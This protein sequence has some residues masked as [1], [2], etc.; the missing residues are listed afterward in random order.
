MSSVRWGGGRSKEAQRGRLGE[1]T[2]DARSLPCAFGAKEP[3]DVRHDLVCHTF[4]VAVG[5]RAGTGAGASASDRLALVDAHNE[6]RSES[7]VGS[8]SPA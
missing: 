6:A 8:L 5:T 4:W 3:D 7:T 2:R 1:L